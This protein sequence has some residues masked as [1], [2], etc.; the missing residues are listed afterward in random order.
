MNMNNYVLIYLFIICICFYIFSNLNN[1]KQLPIPEWFNNEK[2]PKTIYITSKK[3][4]PDYVINN[5]KKLN[6]DYKIIFYNDDKIKEFLKES[7][8]VEYLNYFNKLDSIKGAGPIKADFWRLCIL[9]KYGGI[10]V[11]SDI[12]PFASINNFLEEDTDFLTCGSNFFKDP[13]PHII[14]AQSNDKILKKCLD[15][16]ESYFN[17]EYG[18]WKHSITKV[19]KKA[20]KYYFKN[21]N[22]HLEKN[23]YLG[24]YKVQIITETCFLFDINKN[25]CTYKNRRILNNRYQNYDPINNTF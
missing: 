8:P 12:E 25:Y 24:D 16:Y 10:Y 9:Y 4:L 7:Y 23:Y 1:N 5:W 22:N 15:I 6:P 20:L 14:V 3:E 13:N 17:K 11:D 19:M 18:Y 2:I 21:Y